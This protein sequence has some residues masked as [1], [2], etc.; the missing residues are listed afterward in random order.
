MIR[1]STAAW[2]KGSAETVEVSANQGTNGIMEGMDAEGKFTKFEVV[3]LIAVVL[4]IAPH[5]LNAVKKLGRIYARISAVGVVTVHSGSRSK[6]YHKESCRYVQ[7]TPRTGAFSY[8]STEDARKQG[9]RP[10]YVCW[11]ESRQRTVYGK[12]VGRGRNKM[13]KDLVVSSS[14]ESWEVT[15]EENAGCNRVCYWCEQRPCARKKV[16]HVWCSCES[17][18]REYATE[19]WR[20]TYDRNPE[21]E[22]N[23]DRSWNPHHEASS[24]EGQ[25]GLRRRPVQREL[26]GT[27]ST[28]TPATVPA[29][30]RSGTAS[31]RGRAAVEGTIGQGVRMP[32]ISEEDERAGRRIVS[33]QEAASGIPEST[34]EDHV[35]TNTN[36]LAPEGRVMY[37]GQEMTLE[38][39]GRQPLPEVV[40]EHYEQFLEETRGDSVEVNPG[41]PDSTEERTMGPALRRKVRPTSRTSRMPRSECR[42]SFTKLTRNSETEG[43]GPCKCFATKRNVWLLEARCVLRYL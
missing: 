1:P 43:K 16:G 23:E 2:I 15:E 39:M 37:N 17:C 35:D 26:E 25:S 8:L 20:A 27:S 31:R 5:A 13:G 22:T 3:M 4:L 18:I 9:Y 28:T 34:Y 12:S 41:T 14:D 10:C 42:Q 21:G 32:I 24:S 11:P 36:N 30:N 6:V 33:G 7:G 40:Q 19:R 38:K 29:R